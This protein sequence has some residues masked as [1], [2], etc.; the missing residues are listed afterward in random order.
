MTNTIK[1]AATV[2][3]M[4]QTTAQ[5]EPKLLLLRRSPELVF[6]PD[7]WVFPGGALDEE[8]YAGDRSAII[9]AVY[10][11][12]V[13]EAREECGLQLAAEHLTLYSYWVT[14][15]EAPRRFAT[16]YCVAPLSPEETGYRDIEVDGSEIIDHQWLTASE[17]LAAFDSGEIKLMPPTFMSLLEL[18]RC[19]S[20][21]ALQKLIETREPP[22]FVPKTISSGYSPVHKGERFILYEE[23]VA[24]HSEDLSMEGGYHRVVVKGGRYYY[25]NTLED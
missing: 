11:A 9:P 18:K 6:A 19:R 23:D 1:P 4:L 25:I 14:P 5:E 21:A 13:R 16:W 22:R 24:Y 12:A 7:H 2:I 10:N 3:P 20:I 8:D 15:V 17:A